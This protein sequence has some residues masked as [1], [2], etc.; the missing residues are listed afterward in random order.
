MN[1]TY[2]NHPQLKNPINKTDF[3]KKNTR[4]V[5]NGFFLFL[6]HFAL[7]ALVSFL[8]LYFFLKSSNAQSNKIHQD[9]I[10][11]KNILN[12][13]ELLKAKIDTIYDQ[14]A[15]L[16]TGKVQ[17]DFFLGSYI[18]N[19]IQETRKII[20]ADSISAFKH[21][22]HLLTKLDTLLVL[23]NDIINISVKER[24]ALKDLYECIGKTGKVKKELSKDP[25]RGFQVK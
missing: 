11:Y 15:L 13:Q 24:L 22:A 10:A 21:Y 16:N 3:T 2:E 9:I 7:L 6:G 18:S 12:K 25:T 4:E 23:K 17:N 20:G 5:R 14:M 19:N 1:L 8:S